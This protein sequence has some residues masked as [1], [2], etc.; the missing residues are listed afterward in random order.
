MPNDTLTPELV[1]TIKELAQS[2]NVSGTSAFQLLTALGA[3]TVLGALITGFMNIRR[4]RSVEIRNRTAIQTGLRAEIRLGIDIIKDLIREFETDAHNLRE[5][6]KRATFIPWWFFESRS[7]E[8]GLLDENQASLVVKYYALHWA[9]RGLS[10]EGVVQYLTKA[11]LEEIE[12]AGKEA[13]R[14]LGDRGQ[15]DRNDR[16]EEQGPL[17]LED[18][19]YLIMMCEDNAVYRRQHETLRSMA[20]G[21]FVALIAG[22]LAFAA[23]TKMDLGLWGGAV[24]ITSALGALVSYKHYERTEFHLL[25]MRG[26][27][28]ALESD[29]SE[30]YKKIRNESVEEHKKKLPHFFGYNIYWLRLHLLSLL[31]YLVTFVIGIV[32]IAHKYALRM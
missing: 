26:F 29:V 16:E 12:R 5:V 13:L 11:R 24:C 9:R 7:T 14:A 8:I 19:E 4:D 25:R 23:S 2:V 15:P 10:E 21:F 32:L 18:R 22:L 27:R 30:Q 17:S 3:G 31:V 6:E 20:D 1:Q 28:E